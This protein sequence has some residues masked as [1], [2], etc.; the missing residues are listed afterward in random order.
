MTGTRISSAIT[1]T[2]VQ[3]LLRLRMN[4][5]QRTQWPSY[6]VHLMLN[7]RTAATNGTFDRDHA[8]AEWRA[9]RPYH[10]RTA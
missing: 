7:A 5:S 2:T 3:A 6:R 10:R 1:G 9:K 4:A 8:A